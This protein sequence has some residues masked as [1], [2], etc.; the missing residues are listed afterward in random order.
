MA[1]R[2]TTMFMETATSSLT[3]STSA[4]TCVKPDG[5]INKKGVAASVL[6]T[7]AVTATNVLQECSYQQVINNAN[8]YME[9]MS[10]KELETLMSELD[11]KEASL[12]IQESTTIDKPVQKVNKR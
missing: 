9:S 10:D 4:Q 8:I 12:T 7:T 3:V 1:I 2:T 6:S 5:T 11:K